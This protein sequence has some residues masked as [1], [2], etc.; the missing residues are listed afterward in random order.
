MFV[1]AMLFWSFS[2]AFDFLLLFSVIACSNKPI[3]QELS[4]SFNSIKTGNNSESKQLKN[5]KVKNTPI[6]NKD[7]KSTNIVE[8]SRKKRFSK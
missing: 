1:Y 8:S 7:L 3:G 6:S 2:I 4:D 5:E